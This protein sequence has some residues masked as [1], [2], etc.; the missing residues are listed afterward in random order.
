LLPTIRSRCRR[1]NLR[2][3]AAEPLR[4]AVLQALAAAQIELPSN[5]QWANIEHLA[6]GSVRRALAL[7]TGGGLE[8]NS[9]VNELLAKLPNIDWSATHGLGD[10]LA[11]GGQQQQYVMFFELMLGRLAVLL[12]THAT[13]RGTPEDIQLGARLLSKGDMADWASLWDAIVR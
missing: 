13:G 6:N 11:A 4:H 5:S 12:R 8:L 3:L 7:T 2:A 10:M 9:R 1:L